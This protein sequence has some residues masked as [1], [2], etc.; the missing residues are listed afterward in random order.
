VLVK[1]EL[2]S[3][4]KEIVTLSQTSNVIE[5]PIGN[6]M[7][8][9]CMQYV[10]CRSHWEPCS[11]NKAADSLSGRDTMQRLCK[12]KTNLAAVRRTKRANKTGR[13]QFRLIGPSQ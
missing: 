7:G 5:D 12:L 10:V 3:P 6:T 9:R 2:L 11:S 1:G 13:D 4:G 8:L